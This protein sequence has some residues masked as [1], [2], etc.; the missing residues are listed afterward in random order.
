MGVGGLA[1]SPLMY[2]RR[3]ENPSAIYTLI[4]PY[5]T[6]QNPEDY[7][8]Q[9]YKTQ[10]VLCIIFIKGQPPQLRASLAPGGF[11]SQGP[12]LSS[13]SSGM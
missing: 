7:G 13:P 11:D 5:P 10:S 6:F 1:Q 4:S 3:Q 8:D 2:A 9:E 12:S